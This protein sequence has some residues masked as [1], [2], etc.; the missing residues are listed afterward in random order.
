MTGVDI[1]GTL[2]RADPAVL[3]LVPIER[4]KAGALPDNVALPALLIRSTSNVERQ[5]LKRGERTRNTER[6]TVSVRAANYRDQRA[7][8]RLVVDCCA[9]RTGTVADVEAVSILTAGRG[10]DT[11]GP[12]DSFDQGQDFKVSF[13]A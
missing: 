1:I 6:V 10:P 3:A 13:E 5:P 7:A 11:R 9:G 4:I 8:M 2:L 12:G